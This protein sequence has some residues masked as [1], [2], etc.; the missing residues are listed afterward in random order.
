MATT[1]QAIPSA[2]D[3][4]GGS[5]AAGS[6]VGDNR[7]LATL[8]KPAKNSPKG[9]GEIMRS[10]MRALCIVQHYETT[11]DCVIT[12]ITYDHRR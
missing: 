2:P 12:L 6:A 7:R 3:G 1:E 9:K 5:A 10:L 8:G 4:N 11:A